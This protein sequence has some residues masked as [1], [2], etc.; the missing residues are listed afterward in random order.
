MNISVPESPINRSSQLPISVSGVIVPDDAVNFVVLFKITND[1]GANIYH[2]GVQPN[3]TGVATIN[4]SPFL[5]QPCTLIVE[6]GIQYLQVIGAEEAGWITQWQTGES[7]ELVIKD[8]VKVVVG[9]VT[10]KGGDVQLSGNPIVVSVS[11]S[12]EMRA[13]KTNY[14]LALKIHCEELFGVEFIEEIVPDASLAAVFDIS[15][16]VDQP[17]DYAFEYPAIGVVRANPIL[18]KTVKLTTG[19]VFLNAL[20]DRVQAWNGDLNQQEITVIKGKLHPYELALLNEQGETFNSLYIQGGKFL[21]HLPNFQRVSPDQI[22]KLRYLSRWT[23]EHPATCWCRVTQMTNYGVH[24]FDIKQPL[25]FYPNAGLIE[26]SINPIFM[27]FNKTVNSEYPILKYKFWL[28]DSTGEISESRTFVVDN[29]Y[30]EHSFIFYYINPLSGVDC[31]WLTGQ[32]T[33]GLKTEIETA[34]RPV[35]FGADTKTASLKTI[36]ATSQRTWELNTGPKSP[37]EIL[38]LRDFLTSKDCWMVDPTKSEKLIPVNIEPGDHKLFDVSD[39]IQNLDIK[40]LEA[41]R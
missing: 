37:T 3:E 15:G 24:D 22:M 28:T 30:Y 23:G 4:L 31:I 14:K 33:E 10:I 5:K 21:S 35:P 27:G 32:H 40:I 1:S 26:F 17:V 13:G 11:A 36:S 29:Q 9:G 38:A 19:E 7:K 16:F 34:Y 12:E 6:W 39:D 8:P 20:G 18:A 2:N 25:V 41:H